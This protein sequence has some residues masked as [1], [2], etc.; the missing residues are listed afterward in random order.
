MSH[1]NEP[2]DSTRASG[3]TFLLTFEPDLNSLFCVRQLETKQTNKQ[4]KRCA[5]HHI[6]E[7][8][9]EVKHRNE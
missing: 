3:P 7:Y 1:K 6:I 2:D 9:L 5:Y 8:N 4:T